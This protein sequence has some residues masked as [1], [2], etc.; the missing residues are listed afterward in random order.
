MTPGRSDDET[1]KVVWDAFGKYIARNMKGGKGVAVPKLGHFTFT[2][3][4]VDLAVSSS[5]S[6]DGYRVQ[7]I[8]R[9]EIV[10]TVSQSS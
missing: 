2:G 8:Q 3:M 5:S 4:T 1:A 10:K 7:Q 9:S 6:Y